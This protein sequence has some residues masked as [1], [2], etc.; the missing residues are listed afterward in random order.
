MVPAKY[1]CDIFAAHLLLILGFQIDGATERSYSYTDLQTLVN[2]FADGMQKQGCR[3]NDC[4]CVMAPNCPEYAVMLLA[5]P[6]FG[7]IFSG[8]NPTFTTGT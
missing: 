5:V 4:V 7:A 3:R 2:R 8:L 6:A 1:F